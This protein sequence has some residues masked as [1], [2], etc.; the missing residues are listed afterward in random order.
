M[1]GNEPITRFVGNHSFLSNFYEAAVYVEGVRWPTVEHAY[2]AA[3]TD[4]EASVKLIREAT[5]PGIA[6]K[7]GQSVSLRPDWNDVR[8]Q[9]MERLI[10]EKFKNPFLRNMLIETGEAE[11]IEGNY[12]NDRVWGVCLRKNEGQNLLGKL[13]MQVRDEVKREEADNGNF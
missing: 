7:L 9:I 13:L 8:F 1:P 10:R 12:W 5:T 3:K 6:K 11:L 4:D 2:Q